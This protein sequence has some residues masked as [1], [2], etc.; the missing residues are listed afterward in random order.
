MLMESEANHVMVRDNSINALILH[1]IYLV[2]WKGIIEN[3]SKLPLYFKQKSR[4]MFEKYYP[5]EIDS[6]MK[7]EDKI[8][9]MIEWYDGAHHLLQQSDLYKQDFAAMI[10][11]NPIEFRWFRTLI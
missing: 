9:L 2:I 10:K 11:E 7:V 6:H 5:I 4:E 8:P 1:L 3:Y